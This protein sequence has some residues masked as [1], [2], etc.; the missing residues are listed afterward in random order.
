MIVSLTGKYWNIKNTKPINKNNVIDIILENRGFER[1]FLNIKLKNTMPNPYSFINMEKAV[2]RIT[3]AIINKQPIT[4]LG[5]YD[6]DGISST[7][8][9][10]KFFKELNVECE[11]SIPNRLNDGYGLSIGN[12]EKHKNS[13][14]IAVDCGSS[15]ANELQYANEHN[16][17]IIV[18]DHHKMQTIPNGF[19]II[20]PHRPDEN[21]N[22]KYL[23]ATALAFM[24]IV[25][26]RRLLYEKYYKNSQKKIDL[27][28]Y[29][30]LVAIATICDV[31]P[32]KGLNRAFVINGIKVLQN[33]TNIGLS[34]LLS[35]SKKSEINEETIGFF[36]GPHLN[37]AGRLATA[38]IGV[39][40]LTTNNKDKAELLA[41]Q[42]FKLNKSRQEM[43]KLALEEAISSINE[44]ENY[45][46]L[47]NANWHPG[48]IGILA[49]R[50]KEIYNKPT[51]IISCDNHGIGKASCRSVSGI[52]ISVIIK[53]GIEAGIILSGGGHMLAGGFSINIKNISRLYDFFKNIIPKLNQDFI[54]DVDGILSEDSF[55]SEFIENLLLLSP[56]GESNKTPIFILNDV[57]IVSA[58]ILQ[59][60]HISVNL[61][62]K[63]NTIIKGI[64]F[65][66]AST[67]LGDNLLKY[68][69]KL[70]LLGQI[71][72]AVWK[73][74]K[75]INF[76]II[77][78][79]KM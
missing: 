72:S 57:T 41:Q 73:G 51:I 50:L 25:G 40:L 67:P 36:I 61:R 75:Y 4:I 38:D 45:I 66:C 26:V 5:D 55:S 29:L 48:I 2:N 20:N 44:N 58:N 27:K 34:A 33:H 35:L 15:S 13:L 64:A 60:Q 16:I 31:M 1:D 42:L 43:E 10:I 52:D 65:R 71:N 24:C 49:G 77:D 30:D 18:I 63:N 9:F 6:V 76:L 69:N 37:A 56:F 17:D 68:S 47:F 3:K 78:V 7:S 53:K 21:D 14:I 19:A 54:Y 23:C 22:F 59:E 8:I 32:L 39:E 12:I 62:L 11:Y 46:C 79:A 74:K 28:N 70:K